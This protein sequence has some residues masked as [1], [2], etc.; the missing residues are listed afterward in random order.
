MSSH[1]S[2]TF[3]PII[4]LRSID[5]FVELGDLRRDLASSEPVPLSFAAVLGDNSKTGFLLRK[6][7][8]GFVSWHRFAK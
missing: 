5:R 7:V 4:L 6:D 1:L 3:R 2:G 8:D